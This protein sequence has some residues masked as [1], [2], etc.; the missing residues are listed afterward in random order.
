MMITSLIHIIGIFALTAIGLSKFLNIKFIL[1]MRIQF[2]CNKHAAHTKHIYTHI[3][4]YIDSN[5]AKNERSVYLVT[6]N[7]KVTLK[8]EIDMHENVSC[9][10]I[11]CTSINFKMKHSINH[12]EYSDGKATNTHLISIQ[13]FYLPSYKTATLSYMANPFSLFTFCRR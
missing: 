3:S 7:K 6:I 12:L 10:I 5:K 13:Q 8:L 4:I 2:I 1:S 11:S 9:K